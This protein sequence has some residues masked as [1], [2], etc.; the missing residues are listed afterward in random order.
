MLDSVAGLPDGVLGL[1]ANGTVI[2]QDVAQALGLL[3]A[4][5][6]GARGLIVFL[7]PDFDGYLS[8]LVAGLGAGSSVDQPLFRKWALVLPDDM[9]AEATQLGGAGNVRIFPQSRHPDALA[10]VAAPV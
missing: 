4:D 8:E 3:R 1:K 7:D 9:I 6:S 10:W 2:A 5:A